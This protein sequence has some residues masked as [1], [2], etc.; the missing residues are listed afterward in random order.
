MLI[1]IGTHATQIM[2]KTIIIF[3]PLD[4][5]RYG[6]LVQLRHVADLRYGIY[7]N[8]ERAEQ[9][10]P[11]FNL[12]LWGRSLL[13]HVN[14]ESH[15]DT[16]I[17]EKSGPAYYLHGGV[18]AWHYPKF[19][20]LLKQEQALTWQGNILAAR[21]D[22][23]TPPTPHFFTIMK[24]LPRTELD[25]TFGDYPLFF[26]EFLDLRS[27]AL[28]HD[29]IFWR[30]HNETDKSFDP[31]LPML[32]PESIF[33][34]AGADISDGVFID[35][36]QGPVVIDRGVKVPPFCS[37][38]GP[39]YLGPDTQL[40]DGARI[41]ASIVGNRCRL[42][43]EISESIL[44]P[45]TEKKHTGFLGQALVGSWVNI[46]AGISSGQAGQYEADTSIHWAGRIFKTDQNHAG[47][48]IGDF[49]VLESG[50]QLPPDSVFGIFSDYFQSGVTQKDVA[51]FTRGNARKEINRTI[52]NA[53]AEL[54]KHQLSMTPALEALIRDLWKTP[55]S[56][57][58]W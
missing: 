17:N 50:S 58:H 5:T 35:A 31:L 25:E 39:L 38:H 56:G 32:Q 51:D 6:P 11:G 19:I 3:E 45:Y 37:L 40:N 16:N 42:G 13:Q 23:V 26:R 20:E 12:G 22:S 44:M 33:I 41:E 29:L 18:P 15:P 53:A 10:L 30:Q 47:P 46:G 36:G 8:W 27:A 14:S 57:W 1:L 4:V 21:I 49:A 34:H 43:G 55:D 48:T 24:E 2:E 28:A 52:R 7:S 54:T 9:L